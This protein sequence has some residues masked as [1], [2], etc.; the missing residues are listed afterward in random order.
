MTEKEGIRLNKYLA[1]CGVCSRREADRLVESGRVEIDGRLAMN[2]ERICQRQVI[3]IDGQPISGPDDLV[4]LAYYKPIGVTCTHKDPHAKQ[5]VIDELAY[6]LRVTYAGRLDQDSEGLL[7]MTNNGHLIQEMM[8]GAK[9]HEK[10]YEVR[11][12]RPI[13]AEFIQAM[14]AGVYLEELEVTTRPCVVERLSTHSIRIVLTQGFNRQIRRMSKACG[15]KVVALKRTRIV[16][17]H[18]DNLAVGT[19]RTIEGD[20]LTKLYKTLGMQVEDNKG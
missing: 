17:I 20:E 18:L 6:E 3:Y 13:T 9:G 12:E 11:L 8:K 7:I 4:V 19:Y 15:N 2:G 10:E 16:N 14:G 1:M 5:N